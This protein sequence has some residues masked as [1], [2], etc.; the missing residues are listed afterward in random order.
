[1]QVVIVSASFERMLI[2]IKRVTECSD[3]Q[4]QGMTVMEDVMGAVQSG[5][6]SQ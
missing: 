1:M 5:K 2:S 4:S 6:R 3:E